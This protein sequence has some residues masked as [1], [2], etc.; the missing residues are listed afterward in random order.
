MTSTKKLLTLAADPDTEWHD[1]VTALSE[2]PSPSASLLKKI[3][4]ALCESELIDPSVVLSV[5]GAD[6]QLMALILDA[7]PFPENNEEE[8]DYPEEQCYSVL[9]AKGKSTPLEI[10]RLLADSSVYMVR[11]RVARR[12][13]LT[14]EMMKKLSQD[15]SRHVRLCLAANPKVPQSL[16]AELSSDEDASVRFKVAVHPN[17]SEKTL[18]HLVCDP[19]EEVRF[20]A[21]VSAW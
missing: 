20:A 17:V 5:P 19:V 8:Y 18:R 7:K 14:V 13:D 12:Q 9:L 16:L 3:Y 2:C 15:E 1:F 21:T 6:K 10:V 11:E 4:H